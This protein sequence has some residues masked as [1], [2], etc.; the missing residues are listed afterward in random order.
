MEYA[1][2]REALPQAIADIKALIA[3]KGWRISFPLE[4]RVAAADDVWLSTAY[5]RPSAYIAVHR[6]YREPFAEYFLA[7]QEILLGYGGRP[8][9]GKLHTLDAARTADGGIRGSTTCG[10]FGPRSIRGACS[11]TPIS[12]GCLVCRAA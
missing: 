2:D 1:I 11:A 6:Y 4:I 8:H 9:W 7:V 5:Q 10:R 12:T 3:R